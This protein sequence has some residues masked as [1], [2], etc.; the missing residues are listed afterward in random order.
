MGF[1]GSDHPKLFFFSPQLLRSPKK[2]PPNFMFGILL[3]IS[4]V[5]VC[6]FPILL[7]NPTGGIFPSLH[8]SGIVLSSCLFRLSNTLSEL[9]V[10][11]SHTR[12]H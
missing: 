3:R 10:S 1:L 5:L 4:F 2:T 11:N 6:L 9:W 7:C 8:Q 12:W